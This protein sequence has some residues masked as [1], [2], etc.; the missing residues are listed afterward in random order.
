MFKMYNF[1]SC[2]K[3]RNEAPAYTPLQSLKKPTNL[4]QVPT[5]RLRMSD[6]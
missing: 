3:E 6:S 2:E 4:L 5:Q 1:N